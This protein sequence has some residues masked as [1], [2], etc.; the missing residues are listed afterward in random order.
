MTRIIW[1]SRRTSLRARSWTAGGTRSCNNCTSLRVT[2]THL[3]CV[4]R[5]DPIPLAHY[6]HKI[7]ARVVLDPCAKNK[8]CVRIT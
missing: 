8:S 6:T 5:A 3:I 4:A 7:P 2:D 1:S